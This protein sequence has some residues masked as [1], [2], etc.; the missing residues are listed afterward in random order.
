MASRDDSRP[1]RAPPAAAPAPPG[2]RGRIPRG[3]AGESGGQMRG[4]G[5]GQRAGRGAPETVEPQGGRPGDDRRS[6]WGEFRRAD[7]K[8]RTGRSDAGVD[9]PGALS[10]ATRVLMWVATIPLRAVRGIRSR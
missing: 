9:A 3:G 8:R 6:E 5:E 4:G 2:G 1:H 7:W 10:F